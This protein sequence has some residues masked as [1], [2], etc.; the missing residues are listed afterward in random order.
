MEHVG[1][2]D[3]NLSVARAVFAIVCLFSSLIVGGI[4]ASAA[5]IQTVCPE[6]Q[7]SP[8]IEQL[9]GHK[10]TTQS[11]PL[12]QAARLL[13][14]GKTKRNHVRSFLSTSIGLKSSSLDDL[15][16]IPIPS[17]IGVWE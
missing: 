5:A 12:Q 14:E 11:C 17:G 13:P 4:C 3:N 10:T 1:R 8:I 6:G 9:L 16:A 15:I 2:V 7:E